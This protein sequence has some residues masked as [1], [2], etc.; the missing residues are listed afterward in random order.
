MIAESEP[1]RLVLVH[2]C[3]FIAGILSLFLAVFTDT[4]IL[5]LFAGPL[6]VFSGL[7]IWVGSRVTFSGPMGQL[8]R[9]A[10]GG[11][12]VALLRLRTLLWIAAGVLITLYGIDRMHE[13]EREEQM[14]PDPAVGHT[15][16]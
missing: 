13:V 10:L 3:V 9:A 16:R 2:A 6:F 5:M 1:S 15:A 4:P 14:P 7:L 12:R 8:L 11:T